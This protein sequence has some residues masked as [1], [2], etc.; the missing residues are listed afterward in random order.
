M[1]LINAFAKNIELLMA[2]KVWQEKRESLLTV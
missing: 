1:A 2:L